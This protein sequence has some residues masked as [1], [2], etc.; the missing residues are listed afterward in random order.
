MRRGNGYDRRMRRVLL[1]V[2]AAGMMTTGGAAFQPML[3]AQAIQ[4]ALAIG[5][6]RLVAERTRFQQSY[7]AIVNVAP[8][9][10]VEIVTP[11]RRVELAAEAR[12]AAGDRSFGQ[13][14]ALELLASSADRLDIDIELTFH[15]LNTYVGVP[16]YG[17]RLAR[18]G[19]P[20]VIAPLSIDR[21]PR[22]G[23]RVDGLPLPL[24]APAAAVVSR[25]PTQPM[26]GGT[27]VGRF[28]TAALDAMATYIVMV[29]ESDREVGRATVDLARVR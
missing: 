7:R 17:V 13:R 14:Q 3:D 20:R 25:A 19:D 24:R 22:F 4:D 16:D 10:Y 11:F 28:D 9:D 12:A 26:L 29:M 6:S 15:P 21:I 2:M 27:I 23:P 5:Q 8:I 1:T 18:A